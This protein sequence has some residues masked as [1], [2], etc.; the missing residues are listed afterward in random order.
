V[1]GASFDHWTGDS[2]ATTP[3]ANIVMNSP[4]SVEA[5]WKTNNTSVYLLLAIIG[6]LGIIV[7]VS[8]MVIAFRSNRR[9]KQ[10]RVIELEFSG[11][12]GGSPLNQILPKIMEMTGAWEAFQSG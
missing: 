6:T 10:K 2:T 12:E 7:V 3:E 4:K 9:L 11:V 5:V 1:L 8:A